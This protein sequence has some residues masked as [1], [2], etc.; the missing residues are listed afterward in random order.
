MAPLSRRSL[1]A[2]AASLGLG[3][4][5][6]AQDAP[7]TPASITPAPI[8]PASITIGA[9]LSLTGPGA[10]LGIPQRNTL[11]LL[12]RT[13]AGRAVR[14]VVLDD[15]TDSSAA[16][17]G[18]RKLI[19]EERA[20]VLVGPTVTPPSLAVLDA[21]GQ[22]E[23]PMLSLAGSDAIVTPQEGARRWAFKT[24]PADRLMTT[25]VAAH[26][27]RNGVKSYAAIAFAT[28]FGDGQ[29]A[30]LD[31]SARPHGLR[32][33]VTVRY[34][35]GDASVTPQV[36]R[37]IAARPDAMFVGASGTPGATPIIEM[38]SRGWTG[39]VYGTQGLG[40]PEFLRIGGKALEGLVFTV[41]PALVAEQLPDSNP[42]KAVA[43]A[44]GRAY[45]DRFGRGTRS[46]FGAMVWD[47]FLLLERAAAVALQA[48]QPGTP[49]FR[50]GLRDGL[51]GV[52]GLVGVQGVY[53]LSRDD[54]SGSGPSSQVLVTV[55]N[56]AWLYL[57]E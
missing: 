52:H 40:N 16:V 32:N 20:D 33:A 25:P 12:P 15:A 42:V 1:V 2:A 39:P 44:Y 29:L 14:L 30:A 48:G 8:T 35:P 23:L 56:G 18:V 46:L 53:D 36:L 34:N 10:S 22:A 49:A 27:A 19:D 47:S 57:P 50:R 54:H 45:E 51:E 21:I 28:A 31:A 11:E 13:I 3:R 43:L 26:M 17:R 24:A 38:R 55:K 5:A 4:G 41:T 37:M 9:L 7:I 6:R